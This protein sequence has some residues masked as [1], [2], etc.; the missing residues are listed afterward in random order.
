M[1]GGGVGVGGGVGSAVGDGAATDG[2]GCG[3][4]DTLACITG[5]VAEAFYGGVPQ[6]IAATAMQRL[7]PELQRI[8]ESFCDTFCAWNGSGEGRSGLR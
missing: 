5:S 4:A 2:V 6:W 7:D 1:G 8:T 3:D